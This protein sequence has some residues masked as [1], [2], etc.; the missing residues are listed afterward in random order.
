MPGGTPNISDDDRPLTPD[1]ERRV[2]LV[3]RA[4]KRM[5]V[6]FDKV[7][8]SPLPRAQRSAEIL[9]E[10]YNKLDRLENFEELRPD[11]S[12]PSVAEWVRSRG[13]ARLVVVGHNPWISLLLGE[14]TLGPNHPPLADLR[15]AGIAAMKAD[16]DGRFEIDWL[17]RPKL[18]RY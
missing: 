12:A 3:A 6:K 15:K 13:E 14:L 18:F 10:V 1:G 16:P 2:R 5:K 4:M 11:R 17:A 8:T 7:A 9:A